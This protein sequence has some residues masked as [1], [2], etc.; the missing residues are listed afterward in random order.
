MKI[1]ERFNPFNFDVWEETKT[2]RDPAG[3]RAGSPA[4]EEDL[5]ACQVHFRGIGVSGWDGTRDGVGLYE[6]KVDLVTIFS[7]FGDVEQVTIRHRVEG[8]NNT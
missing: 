5:A 4:L 2:S 6:N 7:P 8:Q 1:E 3:Q